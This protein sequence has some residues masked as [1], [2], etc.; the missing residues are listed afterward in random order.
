MQCGVQTY[1]QQVH[2]PFDWK[3]EVVQDHTKAPKQL[4][5]KYENHLWGVCEN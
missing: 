1:G 3:N 4:N 5:E 2:R